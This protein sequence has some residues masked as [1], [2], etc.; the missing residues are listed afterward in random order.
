MVISNDEKVLIGS[1]PFHGD[2][3][4]EIGSGMFVG[5]H[6]GTA[7]YLE[8]DGACCIGRLRPRTKVLA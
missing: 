6:G 3:S 2:M 4:F 8:I 1:F 7:L 5:L